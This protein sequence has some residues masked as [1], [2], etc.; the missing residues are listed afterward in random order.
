MPEPLSNNE[1]F[2][3]RLAISK[4]VC[5]KFA[6]GICFC[7]LVVMAAKFVSEHYAT[8]Q[9]LAALLLG[10]AFSSISKYEEFTS[11]IELCAKTV[12]RLGVA[13]L[14]VRITFTQIADLGYR[15]VLI[16]IIAVIATVGFSLLIGRALG[17]DRIKSVLAGTAV[18]ICG[19]SAALA[20]AAVLPA[21]KAN[22]RFLLCT[23]VGV[24]GLSTIVMIV[25]PGM[26][27]SL[28][29]D[30][31]QMGLFLGS[32]IHDV[33]Q[34]FGAGHMI[35]NE[36]AELATYTKMLR[37]TM[38]VP[39]IMILVLVFRV[40]AQRKPTSELQADIKGDSVL[41]TNSKRGT[42]LPP[43]LI[44]FIMLMLAANTGAMPA[45]L[46]GTLGELS[47]LCLWLAMAALGTKT[48]LVEMWQVGH[49]PFLLLLLNTLFI[50]ILAMLM[51]I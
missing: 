15:P 37:V 27:S 45:V 32:S 44:A 39:T 6:P 46:I 17:L 50:A 1:R 30:P 34:V 21:S 19:A 14:G 40:A 18:A 5:G 20:V 7:L 38:L 8:P 29:L 48:N 28:G 31:Y 3:A 22:E 49:K 4:A 16:A 24:T 23:I 10:M 12:L 25:Y 35:S 33:A 42:L 11:G 36:V 41:S 43:F 13:L 47:Q 2:D 9:I 26:V 51:I